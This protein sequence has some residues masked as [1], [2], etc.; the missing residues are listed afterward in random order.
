MR[1]QLL[2]IGELASALEKY[3]ISWWLF[4]GWGLDALLGRLTREHGDVECW[5]DRKDCV[6]VQTALEERG[7]VAL[8]TQLPEESVEY[9][10]HGIQC[11]TALFDRNADGTFRTVGRW[12]D[13]V[14]PPGSFGTVLG[15][16]QTLRVPVMSA[17]GMLTMKEQY[18]S[19]RNGKPLRE[20]DRRDIPILRQLLGAAT[21][22]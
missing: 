8:E 13:W 9:M 18:A 19:L 7:F 2:L 12:D 16:L 20:K 1:E 15:Q 22:D 5:I 14:F 11:S 10:W 17:A 3:Q 4:G 21:G 6:A